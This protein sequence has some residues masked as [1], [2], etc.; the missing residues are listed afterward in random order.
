VFPIFFSLLFTGLGLLGPLSPSVLISLA[1]AHPIQKEKEIFQYHFHYLKLIFFLLLDSEE[2]HPTNLQSGTVTTLKINASKTL[3]FRLTT[4]FQLQFRKLL[5]FMLLK[6]FQFL[7]SAKAM[8]KD[9][10]FSLS[11]IQSIFAAH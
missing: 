6:G 1:L 3:P 5:T 2:Y 11:F 4:V 10:F 8:P 9:Y 7:C